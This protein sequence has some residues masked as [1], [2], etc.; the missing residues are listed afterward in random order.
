MATDLDLTTLYR[1]VAGLV[2]ELSQQLEEKEAK[3][4]HLEA[5]L[6]EKEKVVPS[7]RQLRQQVDELFAG[8]VK[9]DEKAAEEE[10]VPRP[11]LSSRLSASGTDFSAFSQRSQRSRS[12]KT[13][14][15]GGSK[16][17]N[18]SSSHVAPTPLVPT[19]KSES[20]G[21]NKKTFHYND[22]RKCCLDQ[23]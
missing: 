14:S 6:E 10:P 1:Q 5:L 9:V 7:S 4:L 18:A 8:Y 19:A 23:I 2:E 21:L 22:V 12:G 16:R 20:S 17:L 11:V 13:P 15:E 3:I